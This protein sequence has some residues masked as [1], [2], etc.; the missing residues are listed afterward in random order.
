MNLHGAATMAQWQ[1]HRSRAAACPPFDQACEC[2]RLPARISGD[3]I[4]K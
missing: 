3:K 4:K 2:A 1:A